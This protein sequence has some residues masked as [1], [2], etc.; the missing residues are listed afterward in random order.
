VSTT[1]FLL[2]HAAHDNLGGFLAGRLP[3]IHLG[4]EGR[5]QAERLAA[6][7]QREP[8]I[9]IHASPRERAQETAAAVAAARAVEGVVTEP[10]LDEVDFGKSWE[11]K[12]FEVL[13]QDP[14][15]Q[16]WNSV[17]SLARTAAGERMIDIEGRALGMIERLT[18]RYVD[19]AIALVS[20]SEIIKA[21]VSQV[22]GLPTDAWTR[23]EISPASITTIV[24]GDWGAKLL[25]LNE[26]TP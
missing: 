9:A 26:V 19:S 24:T 3:G 12:S 25:T 1:F 15:W 14:L 8:I 5:M 11:G 6:R 22:L 13:Q 7:L 10:A 2:R 23:F 16:K 17:R 4:V 18:M 20:H 21:I